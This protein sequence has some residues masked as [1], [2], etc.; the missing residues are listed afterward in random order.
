MKSTL[1]LDWKVEIYD[2]TFSTNWAKHL[3]Y[4]LLREVL[5]SR[6]FIVRKL[7]DGDEI[8]DILDTVVHFLASWQIFEQLLKD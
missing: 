8:N 4:F 5:N 3:D 2:A 6:D 7:Y 1:A